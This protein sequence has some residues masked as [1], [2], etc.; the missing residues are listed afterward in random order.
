MRLQILESGVGNQNVVDR[1]QG[2]PFSCR[3][4]VP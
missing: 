2:Y 3:E 4:A 1:R